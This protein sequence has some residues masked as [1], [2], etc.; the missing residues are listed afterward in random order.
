M[1]CFLN[2]TNFNKE[3]ISLTINKD[4]VNLIKDLNLMKKEYISSKN[5]SFKTTNQNIK[6]KEK[7]SDESI[8]NKENIDTNLS[9]NKEILKQDNDLSS[10][11]S[12]D[13]K[14]KTISDQKDKEMEETIINLRNAYTEI[15]RERLKTEKGIEKL[16]LKLKIIQADELKSFKKFQREKKF[17]EEWEHARQKTQEFRKFLNEQKNK[18]KQETEDLVKKIKDERGY[19]QK[20]LYVQKIMKLQE[21]RLTNLLMKQQ[22]IQISELR[23]SLI[24]E[25]SLRNKRIAQSVKFIEKTY[26]EKKKAEE[27][28][29]FKKIKKE[30]EDKLMEE[31]RK[32]KLSESKLSTLEELEVC[33]MKKIKNSDEPNVNKSDS[34]YRSASTGRSMSKKKAHKI[35]SNSSKKVNFCI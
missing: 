27:E 26:H 33:L 4:R 20:S 29:K 3:N 14:Q 28:A 1:S 7:T 31:Q 5:D 23:R 17:K 35:I 2:E 9:I 30:L 10:R 15:K 16:Q 19:F 22:K 13:N 8:N 34:R 6:L 12:K 25:D 21:S 11:I 32:K 24:T 18:K